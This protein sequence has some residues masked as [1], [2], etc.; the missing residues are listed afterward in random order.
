MIISSPILGKISST[1]SL[2][3][4]NDAGPLRKKLLDKANT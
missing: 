4:T 2:G 1:A 3:M